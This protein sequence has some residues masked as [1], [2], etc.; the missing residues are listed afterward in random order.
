MSKNNKKKQNRVWVDES[1]QDYN[2]FC[3]MGFA[4]SL[5]TFYFEHNGIVSLI[6]AI[7]SLIGILQYRKKHERGLVFAVVGL[8]VGIISFIQ[9]MLLII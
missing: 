5:V 9:Q 6:G 4:I 8:A 1:K 2:M 3:V 7:V